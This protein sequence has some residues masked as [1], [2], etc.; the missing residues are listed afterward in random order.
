MN[1]TAIANEHIDLYSFVNV[2]PV[3]EP[4]ELPL[5]HPASKPADITIPVEQSQAGFSKET[6]LSQNPDF[7][8]L[9]KGHRFGTV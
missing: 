1:F 6:G 4:D 5:L 7:V 2:P 8:T 3:V 9:P